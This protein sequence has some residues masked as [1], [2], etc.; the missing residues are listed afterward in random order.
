MARLRSGQLQSRRGVTVTA[1]RT[2]RNM[3]V[4]LSIR[5]N[6]DLDCPIWCPRGM[7]VVHFDGASPVVPTNRGAPGL[8]RRNSSHGLDMVSFK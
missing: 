6:S 7:D 1:S 4:H 3:T 5:I 2:R 8:C